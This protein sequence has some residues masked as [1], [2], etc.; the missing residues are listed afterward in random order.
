[1][2]VATNSLSLFFTA[3]AG[4]PHKIEPFPLQITPPSPALPPEITNQEAIKKI[5]QK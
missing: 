4:K 1:M 5:K 3:P 2:Q